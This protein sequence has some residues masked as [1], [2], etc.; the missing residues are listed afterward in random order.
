MDSQI[1]SIRQEISILK[2]KIKPFGATWMDLA[3]IT[4]SEV[5]QTEKDKY[6]V[7]PFVSG[8]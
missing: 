4:L 5:R 1:R 8:I 6:R 2:K 7:I 3:V